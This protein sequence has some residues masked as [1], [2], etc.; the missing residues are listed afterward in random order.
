MSLL[1]YDGDCAFCR[2]WIA[3][4]RGITGD[5]VEYAAWQEVAERYPEMPREN[6]V[7]SVQLRDVNGRWFEA[8]EA[9]LRS[10]ASTPGWGWPLRLYERVPWFAAASEAIYRW[11]ARHRGFL[12]RFTP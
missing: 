9:V 10:L 2:R 5:R 1:V 8:A 4:W 3:R 12:H 7:R 11:V 6:F